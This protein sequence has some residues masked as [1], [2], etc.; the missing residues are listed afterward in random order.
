MKK[1]I[2]LVAALIIFCLNFNVLAETGYIAS[3]WA[4]D[5]LKKAE[6]MDIIPDSLLKEDLKKDITRAEF[7]AV[8]VKLYESLAGKKAEASEENPFTDTSDSEVIKAYSLGITTGV[9]ETI[10]SPEEFLSRE[11]AASMLARV[12]K[13]LTMPGWTIDKDLEFNLEYEKGE[14]FADDDKI[15][16][17]AYDSVYFMA[18]NGIINGVGENYFA[19][20]NITEEEKKTGYAN[21]S[22][23][24]AILMAVRMAEMGIAADDKN[25]GE[26]TEEPDPYDEEREK[27]EEEKSENEYTAAF[28]G[29]SLTEGG[30]TWISAVKKILQ[31]KF[32]E[33]EVVTIN[34]GKGGTGSN[35]GAARFMEDVGNYEPDIVFV[36]FSVNDYGT[37]EK[38]HKVYMESIVRQSK[39]LAKEPVIIFLHAP[40]PV[41]KNSDEYNK[42][43]EGVHWKDEVARHYGIKTI[44]IYDYMQRDY[45][46]IKEEKGY[47]TFTDYLAS[48]YSKSGEGFNVHG[49]YQKYA[50]AITEA[51]AE[52]Y[53]GCMSTVKNAGV[54]YTADRSLA[55][56]TYKQIFVD[57]GA[58]H[59]TGKWETY[60]NENKFETTDSKATIS[61]KHYSYPYFTHGIAQVM[62]DSA[63]FGFETKAE[64]FCLNYPAASAGSSVKVYVDGEEAGT[65]TC[66][67][68]Y[69]AV[70]YIGNW[71][72]LPNDGKTHKVIM[73]VD[74]PSAENYVFRFGSVIERYKK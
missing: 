26:E 10:F 27:P 61:A 16:S 23:E 43:F 52:D 45:E 38:G 70:N 39:K 55:E 57:S 63:A 42:W 47:K 28:I 56:A 6:E 60:T 22:R 71:I 32:P 46:K 7:A 31:E 33:K 44:N 37:D 13:K 5:E 74:N 15:S 62:N 24:Q 9:S 3:D 25:S 4:L 11:Q 48:M 51:F 19:P 35:Y 72:T 40:R 66:Y 49:G 54:Y 1:S 29:G 12:Y 59:Y 41:E 14:E 53:E 18:A 36:E 69:H 2:S 21:A 50:E 65:L 20:K 73:V 64:A 67:S 58:M 30:G 68:Q 17:W 34:A 8:S